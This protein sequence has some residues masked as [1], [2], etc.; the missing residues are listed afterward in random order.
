MAKDLDSQRQAEKQ[1]IELARDLSI[2]NKPPLLKTLHCAGLVQDTEEKRIG[3]LFDLP[4]WV[5]VVAAP[6][7]LHSYLPDE[8]LASSISTPLPTL[9][10]R[11]KLARDLAFSVAELHAAKILYKRLH[12]GN[13]LFF[14]ARFAEG[15][16]SFSEPFIGGFEVSRP[17]QNGELSLDT[18]GGS[19]DLYRH[20][21]LRDP[22]NELQ[23]RPASERKHDVY[24]LGLVLLEIGV[25]QRLETL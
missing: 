12:S 11:L 24:S 8:T 22:S 2:S 19:F 23:G 4:D 13:V 17:E 20:P 7:A 3:L 25:W 9:G 6:R 21:E 18:T 15:A 1:A 5:D 14:P 10:D 16:P